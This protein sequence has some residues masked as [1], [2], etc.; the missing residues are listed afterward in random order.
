MVVTLSHLF[1]I[2]FYVN[3]SLSFHF[4]SSAK[5][6][7]ENKHAITMFSNSSPALLL[8]CAKFLCSFIGAW[9]WFSNLLSLLAIHPLRPHRN[10]PHS[11]KNLSTLQVLWMYIFIFYEHRLYLCENI[12]FYFE[13]YKYAGLIFLWL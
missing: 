11:Y 2:D 7:G 8:S 12:F 13:F 10:Q 9:K 1:W 4:L 6:K 5:S 3:L